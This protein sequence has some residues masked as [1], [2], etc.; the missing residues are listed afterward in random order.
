MP[1]CNNLSY[2]LGFSFSPLGVAILLVQEHGLHVIMWDLVT[3]F[4]LWHMTVQLELGLVGHL[5][6]ALVPFC[7]P[8]VTPSQGVQESVFFGVDGTGDWVICCYDG[9]RL[10]GSLH[11][12]PGSLGM[13]GVGWVSHPWCQPH[14]RQ[15]VLPVSVSMVS[16]QT[17]Y[18]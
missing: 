11:I 6:L 13:P 5:N 14:L 7:Q 16:S 18:M 9:E 3:E 15:A 1:T 4:E 10:V 2:F 8:E 12:C 17:A